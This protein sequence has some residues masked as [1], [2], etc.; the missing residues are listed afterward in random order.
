MRNCDSDVILVYCECLH[1]VLLGNVRLTVRDLEKNRHILES[2][3]NKKSLTKT[4][5]ELIQH[6]I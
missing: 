1:N 3:L 2:V 5:F 4:G 6:T